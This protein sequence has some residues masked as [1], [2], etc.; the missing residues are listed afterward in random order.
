MWLLKF[1]FI[2][3]TSHIS[4]WRQDK[5]SGQNLDSI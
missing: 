1:L 5:N 4:S 2:I 3:Q